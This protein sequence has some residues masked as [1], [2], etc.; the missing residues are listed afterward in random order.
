MLSAS[1][2]LVSISEDEE[3]N[4]GY[5]STFTSTG[6]GLSGMSRKSCMNNLAALASSND[7]GRLQSPRPLYQ[8]QA[9][10]PS[11]DWGFFA[12]E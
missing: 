10:A 5:R 6:R 11:D 3:T 4:V 8:N 9:T 12:D 2:M 1:L 7:I